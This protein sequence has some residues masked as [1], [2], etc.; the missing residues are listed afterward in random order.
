MM[1]DSEDRY[2]TILL[3]TAASGLYL[4]R[5]YFIQEYETPSN[6]SLDAV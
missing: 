3:L 2:Q 5:K 1:E 6:A 4:G